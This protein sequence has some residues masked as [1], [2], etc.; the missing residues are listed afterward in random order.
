MDDGSNRPSYE[1]GGPLTEPAHQSQRY[2]A[3]KRL[4]LA[5]V[6]PAEVFAD[7]KVKPTWV[8]CLVLMVILGVAV[9][10][11]V[12]PH[13]DTEATLRARLGDRADE[14]TEQ[15]IEEI[16]ERSAKFAQYGPLI[17]VVVS[18]IAWALMAAVFFVMLKIVGSDADY[19]HLFSS[20]LHSYWPPSA[21]QMV[22]TA[23]L[24][25]RFDA[26]SQQELPNVVKSHLG[27]LLS[28]DAPAWASSAA[29]TI[30]V[31]NI[32]TVILLVV[33][34]QIVGGVSRGKAIVAA[35]VPWGVWLAAKAGLGA[36][37]G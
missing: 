33:G 8:L 29:S 36:L 13:V 5:F 27:V 18:P 26:I 37:M 9:Q 31:F 32:W 35:L 10:F 3:A 1:P 15:Q 21:I 22:L 6:S 7:I 17:G 24:I 28:P 4:W 19:P 2:S 16:V 12:V 20:T 11:A 14:M 30:S 34:F 23:V 25:Q